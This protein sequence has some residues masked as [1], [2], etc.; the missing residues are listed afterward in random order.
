MLKSFTLLITL[1]FFFLYNNK[2]KVGTFTEQLYLGTWKSAHPQAQ[3]FLPSLEGE[4]KIQLIHLIPQKDKPNLLYLLFLF[5]NTIYLDDPQ[6]FGKTALN[7]TDSEQNKLKGKT[8]EKNFEKINKIFTVEGYLENCEIESEI[9]ILNKNGDPLS[10]KTDEKKDI[11]IRGFLKSSNCDIDLSFEVG[12][13]PYY[14]FSILIFTFLEMVFIILGFLPFYNA[15]RIHNFDCIKNLS[16]WAF[17][18]NIITDILLSTIN[19]VFAMRILIDYFEFLVLLMLFFLTSILFKVRILLELFERGLIDNNVDQRT[20][21]RSKFIFLIKFVVGIVTVIILANYFIVY[22]YLFFVIF[23]YPIFQIYHNCFNIVQK[24]CFYFKLHLLIFCSQ[25]FYPIILRSGIFPFFAFKRDLNFIIILAGMNLFFVLVMILQKYIGRTFF[26]PNCLIPNYYNY[27]K[28]ISN[29]KKE[30]DSKCPIC[31]CELTENP[32]ENS[33][34]SKLIFKRYMKTPCA[35]NF[36]V[37]CLQ[38]W[39][40]KKL[41]CP[42]C[43]SI[44]PPY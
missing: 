21:A 28:K 20:M 15:V 27:Y 34:K 35:H 32:E 31:F 9:N 30:D 36:H 4:I 11:F 43:R 40:D 22:Y 25:V 6:I 8:E 2:I 12:P 1:N 5:K 44:L 39:M 7:L 42:N 3:N 19:I 38:Q 33:K 23:I 37:K 16:N 14:I 18:F 24:H 26:L 41:L 17:F 29:L 10:V 13:E